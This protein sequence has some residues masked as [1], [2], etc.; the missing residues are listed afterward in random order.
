MEDTLCFLI[1]M[2]PISLIAAGYILYLIFEGCKY[3]VVKLLE[4]LKHE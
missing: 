2:I 1:V 3:L 4:E